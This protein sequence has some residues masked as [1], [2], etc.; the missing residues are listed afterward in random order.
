MAVD[1]S[2]LRF[3]KGSPKV[4]VAKAKAKAEDSEWARVCRLVDARDKRRCQ[5]TGAVLTAGAV[6]GWSALERHHLEYR[7]ANKSRRFTATN[8]LTT[9][10]AVHQL[11]HGGALR[12]LNKAGKPA[13]DVREI[14]HVRWN[15]NMIA[16]GEEPCRIRRGLAA[17]ND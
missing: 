15:R 10:R 1:Y 13:K 14:D 8:V 5:V 16:R 4:L 3:P 6:D 12:I 7:S 17:R 11:L 2:V 9:S